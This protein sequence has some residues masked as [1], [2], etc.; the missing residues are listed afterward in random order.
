ML[1]SYLI[2]RSLKQQQTAV[3]DFLWRGAV[4]KKNLNEIWFFAFHAHRF[5]SIFFISKVPVFMGNQT[6]A[7]EFIIIGEYR[8][9]IFTFSYLLKLS[10]RRGWLRVRLSLKKSKRWLEN[11]FRWVR[12]MLFDVSS[13]AE[14]I[15]NRNQKGDEPLIWNLLDL[16]II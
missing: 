3:L 4:K 14:L 12:F 1:S 6:G 16:L 11:V 5:K 10:T 13:E 15:I 8:V 9:Q 2:R 7:V